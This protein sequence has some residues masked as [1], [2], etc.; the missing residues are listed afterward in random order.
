MNEPQ[1]R[2][3]EL[4]RGRILEAALDL[5]VDKGFADVAM[6]EIAERCGVTKSLIHHH[7]GT[8]DA[9][10]EA[11]KEHAFAMYALDQKTEL[12][13]ATNAD[14]RLLRDGVVK[15]FEYLRGN[16]KVVRL[17]AWS[18]LEGDESCGEMDAELVR[19]GA[20]RVRQAQ[21]A[22]IFRNDVNPTHVVCTFVHVC[23]HWFEARSHHAQWPGI[24]SDDEFRDDF[25]KIFMRGLARTDSD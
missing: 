24:G 13:Q 8:K 4:T 1:T 12:E 23:T 22:G 3:A 20:E 25:L 10:W 18:H 2:D 11:V 7:F 17:L 5:F 9:L 6:R 16:P 15:Y 14:A 21:E 19:L